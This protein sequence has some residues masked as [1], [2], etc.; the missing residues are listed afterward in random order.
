MSTTGP[1]ADAPPPTSP[2]GVARLVAGIVAVRDRV[3]GAGRHSPFVDRLLLGLAGVA[4]IGATY[5]AARNLPHV[6]AHKHYVLLVLDGI[7]GVPAAILVN[8][9]EYAG[10]GRALGHRVGPLHA[11][12]VSV[13][14]TAANLL[15]IPGAVI[16]RA[17][18]LR[19]LG[20]N[21]RKSLAVL[22]G[23]GIIWLATTGLL[24]GAVLLID[25]EHLGLSLAFI[26]GGIITAAGAYGLLRVPLSKPNAV[27][28]FFRFLVI[29][30]ASVGV[31][32]IRFTLVLAGLGF[33][34]AWSQVF[35][36]TIATAAASAV[37]ILPGG[38]GL[39]E[40]I[41]AALAPLVG[42]PAAV[43]LFAVSVDRIIGLTGLALATGILTL[44][45]RGTAALEE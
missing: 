27:K 15:P 3:T 14:A 26:G 38:L 40:V 13:L 32:A 22:G 43:A 4:F 8:G 10:A 24:A 16:I 33:H 2:T 45:G 36:L 44:F 29:E 37:G 18:A 41:A 9:A 20:T 5:L 28:W 1:G 21:Y 17:R 23:I 6:H 30:I 25:R 11:A 35:T 39:R 19:G 7:L 31:T 42:M 34:P 12:R